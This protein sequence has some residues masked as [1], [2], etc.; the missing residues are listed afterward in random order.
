MYSVVHVLASIYGAQRV[1]HNFLDPRS[2]EHVK[3]LTH[4]CLCSREGDRPLASK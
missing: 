2:L 4:T 1:S 3:V